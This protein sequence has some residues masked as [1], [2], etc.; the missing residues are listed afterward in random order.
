MPGAHLEGVTRGGFLQLGQVP[1]VPTRHARLVQFGRLPTVPG[2]QALGGSATTRGG[3]GPVGSG[4][5]SGARSEEP[6]APDGLWHWNVCD[7]PPRGLRLPAMRV[8]SAQ[9]T[10]SLFLTSNCTLS[11]PILL[12]GAST[13]RCQDL[14]GPHSSS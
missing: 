1:T 7:V 3:R 12:A 5:V 14:P 13:L 10:T 4:L 8:R 6:A 2:G 9:V 11:T